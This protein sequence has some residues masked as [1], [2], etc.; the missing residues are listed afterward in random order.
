MEDD[1]INENKKEYIVLPSEL[2]SFVY[3]PRYYFFERFMSHKRTLAEKL[4]LFLGRFFHMIH[5]FFDKFRGYSVE[6]PI[7]VSIGKV[8]IVG[9]PDS[10]A[11]KN[12]YLEVIE[13]KSGKAPRRGAWLS[14]VIQASTYAF[15]LSFSTERSLSTKIKIQYRN[16]TVTYDFNS[17]LV[18]IVL[19]V[20][21]DL[22]L[23]KYY[24]ILPAANRGKRCEKCPF[25]E[26]CTLLEEDPSLNELRENLLEPGSWIAHMKVAS[27]TAE[28]F[29]EERGSRLN[30]LRER[31]DSEEGRGDLWEYNKEEKTCKGSSSS[32]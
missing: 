16:R 30:E 13:R 28:G 8:K 14:D 17:D 29:R 3:C 7:V 11:V 1:N 25:K 26:F 32:R 18:N 9:R 22:I 20:I 12:D 23:V 4:R 2:H 24:G 6:N 21:E 31:P 15:A 10:Y 5:G 19:K 27:Y